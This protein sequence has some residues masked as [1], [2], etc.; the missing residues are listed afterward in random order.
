MNEMNGSGYPQVGAGAV[1]KVIRISALMLSLCIPVVTIPSCPCPMV[2]E[3]TE[4]ID[5]MYM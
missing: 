4:Y 1:D 2:W 3:G 5:W